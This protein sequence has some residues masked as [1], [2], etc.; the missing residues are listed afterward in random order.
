MSACDEEE[1]KHIFSD[2]KEF[3]D[4]PYQQPPKLQRMHSLEEEDEELV[5]IRECSGGFPRKAPQYEDFWRIPNYAGLRIDPRFPSFASQP[6][7]G[8]PTTPT[9]PRQRTR[10]NFDPG[11]EPDS[12]KRYSGRLKF[13][14]ENKNYG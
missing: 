5:L 7:I 8:A 2:P 3:F 14:D 4:R 9:L 10:P 13:F 12:T 1:Y 11:K 6:I